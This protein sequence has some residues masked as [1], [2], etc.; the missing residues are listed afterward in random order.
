L[1]YVALIKNGNIS[2][3]QT[4]QERQ[5]IQIHLSNILSIGLVLAG[6]LWLAVSGAKITKLFDRLSQMPALPLS[7]VGTLL[8]IFTDYLWVGL[9]VAG[10][11]AVSMLIQIYRHHTLRRITAAAP[12]ASKRKIAT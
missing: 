11:A 10:L 4:E 2:I 8:A 5:P 12:T 7:I 1:Q 3:V 6:F 9:V